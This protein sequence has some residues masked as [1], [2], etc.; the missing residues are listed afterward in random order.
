VS[1]ALTKAWGRYRAMPRLPR[2]LITLGLA[3]LFALTLLPLAIWFAGQEFLG[4]YLRD[5][6]GSRIGGPMALIADYVGGILSG[7]PGHWLVL[8]GPYLLLLA[9]RA[10]RVLYKT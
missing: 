2:E 8:F 10:G 3:L 6:A 1:N 4:D 7:S 9:A 5:P